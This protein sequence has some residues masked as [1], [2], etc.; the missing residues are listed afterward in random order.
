MRIIKLVCLFFILLILSL[1]FS[2]IRLN[3]KDFNFYYYSEKNK[4]VKFNFKIE[5]YLFYIFKVDLFSIDEVGIK[6]YN[7]NI[8]HINIF[9]IK[10]KIDDLLKKYV[11]INIDNLKKL[12]LERL[13]LDGNIGF[14]S[15]I[16]TGYS[17]AILSTLFSFIISKSNINN[18]LKNYDFRF[19]PVYLNLNIID[20]KGKCIISSNLIHILYVTK[21]QKIR[22]IKENGRTSNRRTYVGSDG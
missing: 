8:A 6:K 18:D 7:K 4:Y 14:R 21:K 15:A 11:N 17:I 9:N 2:K 5:L 16:L 20:I 1:I 12:K 10:E 13:N 19:E 22:R 3:L